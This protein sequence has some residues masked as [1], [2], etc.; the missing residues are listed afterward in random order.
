M[1]AEAVLFY[2]ASANISCFHFPL[3]HPW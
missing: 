2:C 3:T 1:K